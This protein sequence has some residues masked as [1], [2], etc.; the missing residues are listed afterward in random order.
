MNKIIIAAHKEYAFPHDDIYLPLQ[1]GA[2]GKEDILNLDTIYLKDGK[3][4]GET[5]MRDDI[6]DNISSK[7]PGYCE[8]TGLYWAW[9]NLP[10]ADVIG[11]VHYRRYFSMKSA[12]LRKRNG[13]F[14]SILSEG[15]LDELLLRCDIIVPK[16]R[17]YGIETLYSHYAHTLDAHQLDVARKV[18][19]KLYPSYLPALRT[20]YNQRWG[21]M[22][23]MMIMRRKDI[24][25]YCTWLF[26]IL[27]TTERYFRKKGYLKGLNNFEGR[28]FGRISEILFNV[29]LFERRKQGARIREVKVIHAEPED[30]PRKAKS[31]LEAKFAGKKYG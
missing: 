21:Y 18:V 19:A 30:W 31:F 25:D 1:V 22:W 3:S 7:N 5:I 10:D 12:S 8:L 28:L 11:L 26:D 29:W 17:I 13:F 24:E 27:F 15:E 2:A 16:K 9:K 14:Q 6:D 20:V 4:Y 23:N